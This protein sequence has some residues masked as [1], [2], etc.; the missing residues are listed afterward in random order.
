VTH[1]T[2]VALAACL[3]LAFA[4]GADATAPPRSAAPTS[5]GP[6]PAVA[7]RLPRDSQTLMGLSVRAFVASRFYQRFAQ[8]GAPMRPTALDELK[9]ETGLDGERDLEQ[10]IVATG[11]PGEIVILAIGRLDRPRLEFAWQQRAQK[12]PGRS[13]AFLSERT[14]VM[15]ST[16]WVDLVSGKTKGAE[17][18]ANAAMLAL[19]RQVPEHAAF[20]MVSDG[21][22]LS[23]VA[24]NSA[25]NP[26]AA[27]LP[28]GL[29]P[30]K[31]IVIS[32]EVEPLL[33]LTIQANAADEKSAQGLADTLRGFVALAALQAQNKPALRDLPSALDVTS[34]D[35]SVRL[36][37]HLTNELLEALVPKPAPAQPPATPTPTPQG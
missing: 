31:S 26:A 4:W 6:L 18:R 19:V 32:G 20:W 24:A 15:G 27:G 9:R 25:K 10:L 3:L 11:R 22:A 7:L 28:L 13:L 1:H 34:Q 29:P 23:R 16:P 17:L 5:I 36:T 8:A 21:D 37:A 35:A 12:A 14:L 33:S 2:K 30:L